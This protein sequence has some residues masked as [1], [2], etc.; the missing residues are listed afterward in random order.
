VKVAIE[1]FYPL[2]ELDQ[3]QTIKKSISYAEG[4]KVRREEKEE[5]KKTYQQAFRDD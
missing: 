5:D 2:K 4:Q 3:A 1:A